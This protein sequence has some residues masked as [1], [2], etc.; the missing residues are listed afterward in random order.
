[1]GGQQQAV[2]SSRV[3]ESFGA[4]L[5]NV[6]GQPS[7]QVGSRS[8]RRIISSNKSR[9]RRR[10]SRSDF[11]K[12]TF[13]AFFGSLRWHCGKILNGFSRGFVFLMAIAERRAVSFRLRLTEE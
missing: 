9:S 13:S 2:P 5:D 8:G 4:S 11:L 10:I 6:A 1:M 7:P 3:E 12:K